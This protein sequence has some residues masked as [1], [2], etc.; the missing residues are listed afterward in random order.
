M[1]KAALKRQGCGCLCMPDTLTFSNHDATSPCHRCGL[2]DGIGGCCAPGTI[3][4]CDPALKQ[5]LAPLPFVYL[6]RGHQHAQRMLGAWR[7][8]LT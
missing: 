5:T 3:V 4:A 1:G 6:E 7:A 2:H 8:V